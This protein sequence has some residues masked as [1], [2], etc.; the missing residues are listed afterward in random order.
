MQ[1]L[2]R[3]ELVSETSDD[4]SGEPVPYEPG[5]QVELAEHGPAA[6]REYGQIVVRGTSEPR[7]YNSALW[8]AYAHDL[9]W[10]NRPDLDCVIL[11]WHEGK[12]PA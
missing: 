8:Y 11:T 10:E 4:E 3:E 9:A 2:A 1:R 5:L 7:R 12:E 6:M